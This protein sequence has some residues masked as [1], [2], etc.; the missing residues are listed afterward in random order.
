MKRLNIWLF[1]V[2]T[3][4]CF[5]SSVTLAFDMVNIQHKVSAMTEDKSYNSLLSLDKSISELYQVGNTSNKQAAYNRIQVIKKQLNQTELMKYGSATGWKHMKQDLLTTEKAI[6]KGEPGSVWRDSISSLRLASD[7]LLQNEHGPWL[8]YEA[9][10]LDDI[11]S[12]RKEANSTAASRKEAT[13]ALSHIFEQRVTRMEAAAYM[14]GDE[15]RISELTDRSSQLN[16]LL[17]A[18]GN[19]EWTTSE[20]Q[21]LEQQLAALET[22]IHALFAQAETTITI[23]EINTPGGFTPTMLA[24]TIGTFIS[25]LL[26]YTAY[27]KYKQ[28]PYGVKRV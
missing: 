14:V 12:M 4:V 2:L 10:L 9:V 6:L 16:M 11:K 18:K 27:R 15:L 7:A 19:S 28:L 1:S 26:T 3:I 8:Q 22:T 24:F 13:A 5:I 23:P 17:T 25:A 20:K 21:Q